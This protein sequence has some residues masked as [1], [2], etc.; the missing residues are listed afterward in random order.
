MSP[1]ELNS[2]D[3]RDDDSAVR[4]RYLI[5]S[6]CKELYGVPLLQIREVIKF[7]MIKPVPHAQRSM[8][9]VINLRG[10]ILSVL[11]LRMMF[12]L[13]GYSE[14]SG[15]VL[16]V[17]SK[18]GSQIGAVVDTIEYVREILPDRVDTQ[19]SVDTSIPKE[20]FL[21]VAR[22]GEELIHLVN[23]SAILAPGSKHS[24]DQATVEQIETP[25]LGEVKA[26]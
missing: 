14:N 23:L 18:Q 8:R 11:D 19:V 24:D 7:P 17:E 22:S 10:Q 9:G 6:L 3:E 4:S 5:F 1:H 26:A 16:V 2:G 12:D 15:F 13:R 20:H 21:G 25:T